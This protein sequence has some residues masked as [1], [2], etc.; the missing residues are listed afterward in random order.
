MKPLFYYLFS[1]LLLAGSAYYHA[2]RYARVAEEV[3][4][5][6]N[7]SIKNM[8][9]ISESAREE[10]KRAIFDDVK[11]S[12]NS[13]FNW[14]ILLNKIDTIFEKEKFII[15]AMSSTQ[16]NPEVIERAYYKVQK[17]KTECLRVTHDSLLLQLNTL[18]LEQKNI[19]GVSVKLDL[20]LPLDSTYEHHFAKASR[21]FGRLNK[22]EQRFWLDVELNYAAILHYNLLAQI[23]KTLVPER[24]INYEYALSSV[25][26]KSS[27]QRFIKKGA[28]VLFLINPIAQIKSIE[29]STISYG[30]N[31]Q[32]VATKAGR[33]PFI[34]TQ[35]KKDKMIQFWASIKD[36]LLKTE[37]R[38]TSMIWD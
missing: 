33:A 38:T 21:K 27:D 24:K 1:A 12:K 34:Y 19:Q 36:T 6:L 4:Y 3:Y 18:L 11:Y 32:E 29:H 15:N 7:K 10:Q 26:H 37:T 17:E 28:N 35:N 25:V 2:T 20:K 8:E 23:R 31:E 22:H 30:I 9:R 13:T 14:L 16:T 5:P